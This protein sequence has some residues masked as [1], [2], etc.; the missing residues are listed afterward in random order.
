MRYWVNNVVEDS[1]KILISYRQ[2]IKLPKHILINKV[3]VYVYRRLFKNNDM[4][5]SISL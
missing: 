3:I 1:S 4:I 2:T 5:I